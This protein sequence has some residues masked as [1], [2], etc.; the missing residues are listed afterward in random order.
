M[1][2]PRPYSV[3]GADGNRCYSGGGKCHN[4]PRAPL[5]RLA[6]SP[7]GPREPCFEKAGRAEGRRKGRKARR[8]LYGL[9]SQ[10]RRVRLHPPAVA[11]RCSRFRGNI[12]VDGRI[13][14][15][16]RERGAQ[17]SGKPS[18]AK[19]QPFFEAQ[20]DLGLQQRT[21]FQR[22]R[23]PSVAG[24][25]RFSK[26]W[27]TGDER[28]PEGG[29]DQAER[30]PVVTRSRRAGPASVSVSGADGLLRQ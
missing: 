9:P 16:L 30:T 29:R 2:V 13:S 12:G 24:E 17:C 1:Q 23:V 7:R 27:G 21:V 22:S 20:A 26:F 28:L 11:D 3:S 25:S 10:C 14:G 4:S 19:G 5:V 15:L 18:P 8:R 6:A